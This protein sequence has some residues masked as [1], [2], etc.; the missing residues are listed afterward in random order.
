MI[1]ADAGRAKIDGIVKEIDPG[2]PSRV[3]GRV[4]PRNGAIAI[5]R[6]A[7]RV[8]TDGGSPIK[9]LLATPAEPIRR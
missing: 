3:S 4:A 9:S 2:E 8:L 7:T 5:R 6:D 1:A